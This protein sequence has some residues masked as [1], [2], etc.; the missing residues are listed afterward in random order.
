MPSAFSIAAIKARR[1]ASGDVREVDLDRGDPGRRL[2]FD[3]PR[4]GDAVN[5]DRAGQLPLRP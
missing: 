4:P 2:A 5:A 1:A 3:D